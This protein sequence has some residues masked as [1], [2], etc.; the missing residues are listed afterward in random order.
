M[1]SSAAEVAPG[2]DPHKPLR[3]DVRLLG[4]LLGDTLR[5]RLGQ[6]FF[7]T[8]EHV[9]TLAKAA[10]NAE[11]NFHELASLLSALPVD[12][13][14]PLARAFTHFLNLA[15]VAEQ[16]HRIRR[17]RTY[18]R[19]AAA[20][21]QRG[22]CE[23]TFARLVG[24]GVTQDQLYDAVRAM[25]IE[26][27]LTS[28]PTEVSRRTLIHKYNRIASLL[29][30]RDRPDLTIPEQEEVATALRREIEAAWDTDEVRHDRPTP[31][32]EVRSGLIVFEQS[33][34]HALPQ[35]LR[36]VDRAL[37]RVAGREL[38]L[39][40][41]PLRFGSWIG[42]D[43]D[44]NPNVTPDVTR[45]ACLLSRWVA[46]DLYLQEV[47]S[48]RDELSM[49]RASPALRAHVG[50]ARE[51]YR[52]LLRDVRARLRETRAWIERSLGAARDLPPDERVYLDAEAL[53]AP[54]RLC[55]ESLVD[56]GDAIIARGRLTDLL[57]RLS[58][59]GVVLARLDIRQESD[60]HTQALDA[61]TRALGLGS[62]AGWDE[63]RR[64]EFLLG[65][66]DNPRP[67][68][69][70]HLDA[71]PEVRDVLD[72]FQAIAAIHRESLGAYVITM[73]RNASD[74]LAVQLL[75]QDAGV[76]P[77]LRVVPLFETAADLRRAHDVMDRLL[78]REPYRQRIG[79]RQEVMVGYSDSTKDIGRLT[80]AWELY[81]AQENVVATCRR[82]GVEVTLFHGRG[83]SVGRGGGPTYVAIQSQ[84]SGSVDGT[85]R[86]T[87]QGEMIQA[88]FGLP[89][90]AVRTMEV[91]TSGTLDSW[92]TP[93]PPPRAE[94][95]ECMER[96]S[97]DAARIYRGYAHERP[98]FIEY[99]RA[100]TAVG[101]LEDVNIGSRPARRKKGGGIETLRAI[102]WQFAWTQTRLILGAWL[103][104]EEA[105]QRASERGEDD[106]LRQM[107]R[108]WTHF[109]SAVDL[110]EMVLAKTD[111]R[112]A[113]EYDRQLV[114][115]SL[116]PLGA[117]LR[118]RLALAIEGVLRLTGHRELVE[119]NHVLRRSID[120]RNPYVDPINLTQ[121]ELIR[122]LRQGGDDPRLHHAFKVT[123]NGIAAGMRNTG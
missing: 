89:Q 22:S 121:I 26:L 27:V 113:A 62:Y 36:S 87:E 73:T 86:V 35:Y 99:F 54:L 117:D 38:P 108:D 30:R 115:P 41:A 51:P 111:S 20:A 12:A 50:D 96:L 57:R 77:P 64:V 46:A 69:P 31:L 58:A 40:A 68:A 28:H 52:E 94:W 66:I 91:Y 70:R 47:E 75:Q 55:F 81:K 44:G 37:R 15:N 122:R 13:A 78:A 120:V 106:L 49:T 6:P 17:R 74:I 61:I 4:E 110:L 84:P 92:L 107:Y 63:A 32:D 19:D 11:T 72:T 76:T 16:H 82:H 59:F 85:L 90:I 109:R 33:L 9:R 42:G 5:A 24:G 83:G 48:L 71:D 8:V 119:E 53:A 105:L 118:G 25:R 43:R 98:E 123:V 10:R 21:P 45:K 101:E 93:A 14:I 103:G 29:A 112:I 39:D 1:P 79:G 97:A 18:L 2:T 80:A 34:W 3:Q 65:E 114:P 7:E 56:S 102:P 60:R 104:A 95:R 116:Q 67:L 100:A 88:L 23:E